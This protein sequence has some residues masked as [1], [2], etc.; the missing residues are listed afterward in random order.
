M[1]GRGRPSDF[2]A[3]RHLCSPG[4]LLDLGVQGGT[5]AG[6]DLLALGAMKLDHGL[7]EQPDGGL[8]PVVFR[9]RV[10]ERRQSQ[11]I[12]RNI[13]SAC[14]SFRSPRALRVFLARSASAIAD[15]RTRSSSA[16]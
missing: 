10:H 1:R 15:W 12:L 7:R 9:A 8:D 11:F 16:R 3:A 6:L 2:A 5:L 13:R 4:A 14:C